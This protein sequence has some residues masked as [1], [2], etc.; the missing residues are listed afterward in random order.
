[1]AAA[2]LRLFAHDGALPW[3]VTRAAG[4]ASV[5]LVI[6]ELIT[7]IE[8]TAGDVQVNFMLLSSYEA[9]EL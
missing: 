4:A 6:S 5:E 1:V 9:I 3:R 7:S 2:R 8:N